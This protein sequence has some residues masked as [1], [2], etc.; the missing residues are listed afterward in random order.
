MYI[1][2]SSALFNRQPEWVVY[3]EV[4]LTAKEYMREVRSNPSASCY[5]IY[6]YSFHL[7]FRYYDEIGARINIIFIMNIIIIVFPHVR[8]IS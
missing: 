5:R 6:G 3:H 8:S 1:H 7:K 4:V 2:P